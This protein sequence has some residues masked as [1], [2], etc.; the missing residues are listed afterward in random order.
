M[1]GVSFRFDSIAVKG[2]EYR[3]SASALAEI[4]L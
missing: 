1:T 2:A 3:V 4:D